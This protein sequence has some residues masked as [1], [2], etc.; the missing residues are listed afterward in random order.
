MVPYRIPIDKTFDYTL[1]PIG[2]YIYIQHRVA[3]GFLLE[4]TYR[5]NIGLPMVH[6]RNKH[7][8]IYIKH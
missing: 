4:Q 1:P 7:I 6:Y 3:H 8:Y 5:Y 2:T